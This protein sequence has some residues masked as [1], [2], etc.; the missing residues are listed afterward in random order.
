MLMATMMMM[1]MTMKMMLLPLRILLDA[2]A[3]PSASSPLEVR[4]RKFLVSLYVGSP[5]R[6]HGVEVFDEVKPP[7]PDMGIDTG[8]SC[9]YGCSLRSLVFAFSMAFLPGA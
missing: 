7:T 1:V 3:M 8:G 4:S 9:P 6:L 2:R 5:I